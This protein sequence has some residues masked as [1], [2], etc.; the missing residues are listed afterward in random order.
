MDTQW[1]G[2]SIYWALWLG[3]AFLGPELYCLF[4]QNGGTFSAQVW[5]LEGTGATFVRWFVAA[6]IAWLFFHM[7]F[8]IFT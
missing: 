1:N 4:T 5:H 8:H 2:W 7:V 3:V 6:F